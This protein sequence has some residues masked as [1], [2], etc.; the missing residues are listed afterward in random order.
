VA[1]AFLPTFFYGRRF[2]TAITTQFSAAD[3]SE[4]AVARD[5][6]QAVGPSRGSNNAIGR[7]ARI[8]VGELCCQGRN[9]G[10]DRPQGYSIEKSK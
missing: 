4:S 6:R 2:G 1:R 7:V 5:Q 3:N 9:L 10:S 8:V